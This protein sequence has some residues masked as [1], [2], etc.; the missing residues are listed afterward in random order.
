MLCVWVS[1]HHLGL[2]FYLDLSHSLL[3]FDSLFIIKDSL[4]V[5]SGNGCCYTI[6]LFLC[7][8]HGW[9]SFKYN[10]AVYHNVFDI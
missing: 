6:D 4:A 3:L 1:I 7:K 10:V 8:V 5:I 9:L 2:D